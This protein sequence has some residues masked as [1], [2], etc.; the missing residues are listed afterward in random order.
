MPHLH[1]IRVYH[2][3]TDH[4]GV[5]YHASYLR[6]IERARS[7]WVRGMGLDQGRLLA[8]TGT[9]FAVR[10]MEADWLSPARHDDLLDVTTEVEHLRGAR[11]VLLQRI[12]REGRL[13]FEA[14]VTLVAVGSDGRPRRL[15]P[16]LPS[17]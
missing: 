9:A 5:V 13:L 3:D 8:E 1:P 2:E 12:L 14:R 16:G 6:F 17:G 4:T 10:R 7:E 15:P 11:L